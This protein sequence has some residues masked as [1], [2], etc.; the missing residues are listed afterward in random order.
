[1]RSQN[2]PAIAARQKSA[3]ENLI[4]KYLDG[5]KLLSAWNDAKMGVVICD[6]RLRYKALNRGVAEIH[7]MSI[8]E[9]LNRPI[10]MVL[11]SMANQVV[12]VWETVF[13]TGRPLP[14]AHICGKLPKRPRPGRWIENLFPLTDNRGRIKQVGCFVIEL[15]TKM[16]SEP[17]CPVRYVEAA[18]G[19]P[20]SLPLSPREKEVVGLLAQGKSNKE[21]S[22]VLSISVRTV[23]THRARIMRKLGT[24]SLV[25]LV[26]YAI[27]NRLVSFP[28]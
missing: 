2:H 20:N 22:S 25:H 16:F 7:N 8:D 13:S 9:H 14:Y 21:I 19:R 27:H 3:N 4:F 5:Q 1:V 15:P 23:E 18:A 28:E 26:Y 11:G 10:H 24:D 12:P 6:R 17:P